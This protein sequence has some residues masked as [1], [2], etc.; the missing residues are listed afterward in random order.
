M[1]MVKKCLNPTVLIG[2]A[3]VAIFIALFA[4]KAVLPLLLLSA[5]PLSMSAMMVLMSKKDNK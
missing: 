2:L 3:V 4:P 1:E 5:C